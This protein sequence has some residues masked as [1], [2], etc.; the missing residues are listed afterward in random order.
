TV[1]VNESEIYYD[2]GVRIK[3]SE[4]ART[5]PNRVGFNLRFGS[6]KLFR[7]IHRTVAI[8][9]SEGQ[10][11]G[12]I[13]SLWDL[14]MTNAGGVPAEYNDLIKVLAP[15]NRHTSFASLQLARY[16]SVFLDSQFENGASGTDYEYELIYYPTSSDRSTGIKR[17]QPDSVV[18]SNIT[19]LGD[20]KENYRW[21]FNIKNNRERD[22]YAP[23]MAMAKHFDKRGTA[24]HDTLDQVIDVEQ[25][26]RALAF[27]CVS[28]AGD[29]FFSNA[30]HNGHLYALPDGRV[31]YFPH[32]IDFAFN[33]S[34]S[35]TENSQLS[36]IIQIPAHRRSY[37]GHLHD[38]C[39][40]IFNRTYMQRWTN[41]Y[42]SLVPGQNYHAHLSYLNSR[43]RSVLSQVSRGIRSVDFA[44]TTNNGAAFT[45]D[46]SPV[47]LAGTGWVDVRTVRLAG[48][49][50]P[51]DVT[52]TSTDDWTLDLPI[53]AGE[54]II[55]LEAYDLQGDLVASDTITVTNS[56]PSLELASATNIAISEIHYNPDSETG[57]DGT[58]EFVELTNISATDTVDLTG[59]AFTGGI[60]YTFPAGTTLAPGAR[61][62][63]ARDPSTYPDSLGPYTGA[64][65]NTGETL[66]LTSLN[67]PTIRSFDYDDSSPWPTT[68]DGGG[69][70]LVLVAPATSPDHALPQNW[71]ASTTGGGNPGTSDAAPFDPATSTLL[72]YA[73]GTGPDLT[74]NLDGTL[75]FSQ[76]PAADSAVITP[77]WSSDLTGWSTGNFVFD[78]PGTY[79][80]VPPPTGLRTVHFRLHVQQRP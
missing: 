78:N 33:A 23:I 30:R 22:D 49:A 79:R 27:S 2:S 17:P 51:L 74:Y 25:W 57:S 63:L 56:S 64:L 12:T 18:G 34:R 32:D 29:S 75:T 6:D 72:N 41:H 67:G 35:I 46:T 26:L 52:W 73:L 10:V 11:V 9:R 36:T 21:T 40:R 58:H 38:I 39:S 50:A 70:S 13:E 5:A 69:P 42:G 24:F 8:D 54:N 48:S 61:L 65:D 77:Q 44:I 53:A 4:R 31:L 55:T 68:P 60:T 16:G 37:Y 59:A 1:I 66:T 45:T 20:D 76:N 28:G 14:T 19:N 3:G 43:S 15:D 47:T 7:G 62:V 71:R 80:F